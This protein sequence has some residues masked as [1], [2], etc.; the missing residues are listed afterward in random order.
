MGVSPSL[1]GGNSDVPVQTVDGGQKHAT[2]IQRSGRR[3]DGVCERDKQIEYTGSTCQKAPSLAV[4]WGRESCAL[5]ADLGNN[6]L[7]R[8]MKW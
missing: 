7:M 8:A 6:A 1:V 2:K 3:S 5:T 4:T